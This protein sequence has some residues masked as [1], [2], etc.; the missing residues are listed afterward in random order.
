MK[1]LYAEYMAI[2]RLLG[3]EPYPFDRWLAE[4]RST[5]V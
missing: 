5:Q 4:Y 2:C 3:K 1:K